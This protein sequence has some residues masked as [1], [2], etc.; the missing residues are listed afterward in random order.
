MIMIPMSVLR[1]IQKY[2]GAPLRRTSLLFVVLSFAATALIGTAN[3]MPVSTRS[4]LT[5]EN[6]PLPPL[7]SSYTTREIEGW[8]VLVSEQLLEQDK[9]ATGRALE[10]LTIQL[11][12]INQVV[13]AAVVVELHKV[14]LWISPEYPNVIPR[15]EYH[16]D[17]GWLRENNR[18]PAMEKA[19]EFTN[20]R[21]FEREMLR[22]PNFALHELAHAYHDRV[23]P[24]GFGNEAIKGAFDRAKAEG[25][26][27]DVEQRFGDGRSANVRAYAIT[28]PQEYFAECSEAFFSTN[29]FFPFT[30]DQ[31]AQFDPGMFEVLK[32]VWGEADAAAKPVATDPRAQAD[33]SAWKHSGSLFILT[34]PEGA[35]LP[36]SAMLEN[37]PLLVRLQKNWQSA[38]SDADLR[39]PRSKS[40]SDPLSSANGD[41]I[42]FTS[43]DGQPLVYQVEEW[44]AANGTASIWVR[45]PRITG[46]SRQEIKLHWGNP[47]AV[48][49]S[50]G[51]AVF[52]ASNGN[53][54]VLHMNEPVTDE[55]GSIVP[56]DERTT[57]TRGMIG[58]ARHLAGGQGIF[59]GEDIKAYPSGVGPMST[60][61]WFRADKANGNVLAWGK[62]QRPGKVMMQF[63]SPP[64]L[65]IRCYFADVEAA[66]PLALDQWYHVVH[67]YQEKDSRVYVNGRLDGVSDPLLDIPPT[68]SLWIGGWYGNYDFHGDVD[69]VRISNVVRTPDWIRLQYENQKTLQT[70]VGHVVQ[71]GTEFSVSEKALQVSEGQTATVSA[72]AGGAQKVYWLLVQYG[73][74]TIVAVDQFSFDFHAGR[75]TGDTTATLQFRALFPKP[76]GSDPLSSPASSDE[77]KTLDI[78]ITIRESIPEPIVSL[79]APTEWDGRTTIEV[80]PQIANLKQMQAA[81]AGEL[82]YTWVVSGLAAI[83]EVLPDR[84]VLTRAQNSGPMTVTLTLG[85]GGAETTAATSI[86]VREPATDPWVG[87]T[88]DP[89]EKPVDHQFYPRDDRNEGTLFCNGTLPESADSIVLK[90]FADD[91]PFK[92]ET[93]TPGADRKYAFVVKLQPGLIKYR[94]ELVAVQAKKETVLHTAINLVCGDA[95]LIDG[96]SNALATD[97]GPEKYEYS[98]E[99]IRSFGSNGGDIS[100]G[101]GDAV[102]REG[103]HFQIGCWGMDLAKSLVENHK[104]PICIINGAVGG[105]LIEAHQRSVDNPTDPE[106]IYGRMLNRVQQARLTHGIRG[107]FWH[108]GENNQGA[109]GATGKYGWET[110]EQYF[111]EMAGAWQQDFPNIQHY[112]V[113]QIWPNACGMGGNPNS[114]RLR[115]VQRRLPHLYSNMT[116]IATLGIKPEGGCHYPPAG[117]A[118]LARQLLPVV[119]QFNYGKIYAQ[120]VT[121]PNLQR[122][123]YTSDRHDEI[124][125]EFDQPMSWDNALISQFYLDG[126]P[127]K[128]ASGSVTGKTITLKLSASSTATTITYLHDKSW[129]PQNLLLSRTSLAALTFFGVPVE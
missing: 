128:I 102:R 82:K 103:G 5:Q 106:T 23:L 91:K 14:P 28:N 39:S 59:G 72:R 83:R 94:V 43:A 8:T 64:S 116:P 121:S 124:A 44:D 48:S 80:V 85:N 11:Q 98:S 97:W 61:A 7:P 115:D 109:Q 47:N 123:S 104:I 114:D 110:Y 76:P 88:P 40:G 73:Q 112:Y 33:Y 9:E 41:D 81:G 66:T 125:L 119:E 60:E 99:W 111:V 16:P 20:V 90:V 18:D 92:T 32:E 19:V 95:Y 1:L 63:E 96:Q 21:I 37:F 77:V 29:D 30:R 26:Y 17:A 65:A 34:T 2:H 38:G 53:A 71:P 57:A 79:T 84:L 22:M 56:K 101:W 68:S 129:S 87:R 78:P 10:L 127:E 6:T 27:D 58:A 4:D 42:R 93:Q 105:T 50:S 51:A 113:F 100:R 15:A 107:V 126:A 118:E 89:D 122:A 52:N 70:A 12:E 75:V 46:N 62:E 86:I 108:Q 35:D 3:A 74:E 117:Y 45:I 67:T 36:A 54:S 69:E 55:V 120:P 31:L 24:D 25:L 49:E 13:P